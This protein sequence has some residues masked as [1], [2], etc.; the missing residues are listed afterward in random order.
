MVR[1]LVGNRQ[2]QYKYYM[3]LLIIVIIKRYSNKHKTLFI[4]CSSFVHV[5]RNTFSIRRTLTLYK[6]RLL[7]TYI[8]QQQGLC[9]AASEGLRLDKKKNYIPH[10]IMVIM[11]YSISYIVQKITRQFLNMHNVSAYMRFT[12]YTHMYVRFFLLLLL[13]C[14]YLIK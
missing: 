14:M 12:C 4:T 8:L 5:L 10:Y 7:W 9:S 2:Q 13:Y 1:T 11:Q 3:L 6:I